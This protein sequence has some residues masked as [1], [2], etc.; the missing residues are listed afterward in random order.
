MLRTLQ[1]ALVIAL[2]GA[3]LGLGFNTV[4][5]RRIP[6]RTPPPVVLLATDTIPLPEAQR[7][8]AGGAAFFLDAR[9]ADDYAAGHIPNAFSL[10]VETFAA[11]FPQVAP[12]LTREME[13]VIYCDGEKCELSHQLQKSL[14]DLGYT[15][16]RVL[17]NAMTVWRR[18]GLPVTMG[19]EP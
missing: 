5:P 10:P 7:L 16:S 1:R 13:L 3:A 18:A 9:A 8:W 19:G 14:R 2:S 11:R 15:K 4:S 12:M 6:F 17:V